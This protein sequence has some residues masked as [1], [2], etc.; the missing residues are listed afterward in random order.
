MALFIAGLIVFF[1]IH[2]VSIVC[3]GWRDKQAKT[4][5]ILTWKG[6]YSVIA[7]IGLGLL[8]YGYG[9]ARFDPV[10]LFHPPAFLRHVTALLMVPFFIL[11]IAAYLPGK[12]TF[13]LK[14][15]MLVAVKLWALAHLLS[16][17]TLADALLFG[18]FL[19]WAVVDRISLKRRKPLSLPNMPLG[20]RND[21]IAI[22]FGLAFYGLF[23][24]KLHVWVTGVSPSP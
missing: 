11:L 8:I 13:F 14:H 24:V 1:G 7:A 6:I 15:P 2:S 9:Q 21:I 12:I 23:V 16:N 17:G 4:L 5:G 3:P 10:I 22:I 18:S 20:F 19:A